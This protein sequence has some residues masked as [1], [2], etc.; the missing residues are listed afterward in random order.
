MQ[1]RPAQNNRSDL[2]FFEQVVMKIIFA[3]NEGSE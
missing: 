3:V 2:F 1:L